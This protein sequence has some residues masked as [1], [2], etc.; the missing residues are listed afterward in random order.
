MKKKGFTLSEVL[1]TLGIIGVVAAIAAPLLNN[2]IPDKE[3]LAVLKV[4]K[5]LTDINNDLLN[6]TT[7][8][9]IPS[10]STCKGFTCDQ[11]PLEPSL[12]NLGISGANKYP[13]LL[14]RNLQVD[15]VTSNTQFKTIDGVEW[16]F[17]STD[18]SEGVVLQVD[19]KDNNSSTLFSGLKTKGVDTFKFRIAENGAVTAEDHLTEVYLE[20]PHQLRNKKEDYKAASLKSMNLRPPGRK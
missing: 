6:D 3:K 19:V 7:C 1:I 14:A 4:Y 15:S 12:K 13:L 8:Y 2:L 17:L 10:G 16:K 20:T 18:F 11:E 9:W 5:L